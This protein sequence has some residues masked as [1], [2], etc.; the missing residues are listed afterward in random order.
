MKSLRLTSYS[1]GTGRCTIPDPCDGS[2]QPSNPQSLNRDTYIAN[3]PLGAT[4]PSRVSPLAC[5]FSTGAEGGGI[6][7]TEG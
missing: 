6:V 4:D 5:G 2:Y 3:R 1:S 7:F